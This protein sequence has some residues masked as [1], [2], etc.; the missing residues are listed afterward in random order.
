MRFLPEGVLQDEQSVDGMLASLLHHNVLNPKDL[1]LL[2]TVLRILGREDLF[3]L[4][5]DYSS[6]ITIGLPR[7]QEVQ[8]TDNFF[9]LCIEL[10][11]HISLDLEGVCLIKQD[12][13]E[14]MGVAKVP[15][16]V[17]FLGWVRRVGVVVQFQVH[18]SLVDRVQVVVN[19]PTKKLENYLEF[20]MDVKKCLFRYDL[21]KLKGRR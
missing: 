11:P 7:L 2:I 14:L 15:Y 19:D 12:L 17:Q 5:Y 9:S 1:D 8:N 18:M 6:Q 4:L 10:M 20:E 3:P 21:N 13:C 16:L